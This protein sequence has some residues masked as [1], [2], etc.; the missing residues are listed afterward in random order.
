MQEEE[1]ASSWVGT[2]NSGT[3]SVRSSST[4]HSARFS[5]SGAPSGLPVWQLSTDELIAILNI[6]PHLTDK[7]D[8]SLKSY[9]QKY[10]AC[11]Q[12]QHTVDE[13]ASKG[14]WP[15]QRKPNL[16]DLIKLFVS[17]SMWHS[18]VKKLARVP[19]YPLMQEWLEGG[20]NAPD[21]M[22]VWGFTKISYN[23][24]DL[25]AYFDSYDQSKAGKGKK[26]QNVKQ[27]DGGSKKK[28]KNVEK[29]EGSAKGK[30]SGKK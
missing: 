25:M 1:Q 29:G 10:K 7:E 6:P 12:A 11:M 16:T 8:T 19:N 30:K 9:Y 20:D 5:S 17:P 15:A 14:Q 23:F 22:E 13:M 26:K 4:P 27:D 21:D 28:K 3:H 18:H 2:I 24:V